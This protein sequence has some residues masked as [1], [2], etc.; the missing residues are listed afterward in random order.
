MSRPDDLTDKEAEQAEQIGDDFEALWEVS[1]LDPDSQQYLE[2][3]MG[4]MG[5]IV[6]LAKV[7]AYEKWQ[8]HAGDDLAV[9]NP[10]LFETA[11]DSFV[12]GFTHGAQWMFRM[13]MAA[14]L[15]S[16]LD[17]DQTQVDIARAELEALEEQHD[18]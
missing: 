14:G 9:A 16:E 8:E 2:S 1:K 12:L 15:L 6:N 4:K 18:N 11:R 17:D 3:V 13:I 5:G 10:L 7:T